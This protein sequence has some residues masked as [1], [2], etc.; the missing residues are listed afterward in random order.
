MAGE[1]ACSKGNTDVFVRALGIIGQRRRIVGTKIQRRCVADTRKRIT[2]QILEGAVIYLYMVTAACM[3]VCRRVNGNH[4]AA[5]V[6]LSGITN[7]DRQGIRAVA[8]NDIA[9]ASLNCLAE[10]QHNV[11]ANSNG[12]RMIG[13]GA[14]RE[15]GGNI[16]RY[17]KSKGI[18]HTAIC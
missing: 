18:R 13:W 16:I 14:G 11:A 9:R 7:A 2:C 8:D 10:G 15:R 6:H 4:V 1:I 17:C 3:Q 12:N 5:D